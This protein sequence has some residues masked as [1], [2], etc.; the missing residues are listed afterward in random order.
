MET[1]PLTPEGAADKLTDL[2]ALSDPALAAHAVAIAV[3]FKAW[4]KS[5]FDLTPAQSTYVNGMN[6]DATR[7]FGAQC[8]ACFL[9]RIN[10]ELVYPAP[11]VTP[12]YAKWTGLE[13]SVSMATDGAGN[14]DVNGTL[15]FTI[16]YNS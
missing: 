2:Y 15:T 3:D 16:S 13:S 14:K 12:G 8:S 11:P 9:N 7:F 5:N 6:A 4:V 1:Y 10:I